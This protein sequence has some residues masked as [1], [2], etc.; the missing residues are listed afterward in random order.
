MMDHIFKDL[1]IQ[2]K[3]PFLADRGP[4][5]A[6]VEVVIRNNRAYGYRDGMPIGLSTYEDIVERLDELGESQKMT[7]KHAQY[8]AALLGAL[9]PESTAL[10][11]SP[12]TLAPTQAPYTL[13]QSA[14]YPKQAEMTERV[15]RIQE[16]WGQM[17]VNRVAQTMGLSR[18]QVVYAIYTY[19]IK[20]VHKKYRPVR[21]SRSTFKG[22]PF[23]YSIYRV[24]QLA[25]R[26]EVLPTETLLAGLRE[27]GWVGDLQARLT[28]RLPAVMPYLQA[29]Q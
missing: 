4:D 13:K 18:H 8:A 29:I 19:G 26:N 27:L 9:T 1:L 6:L 16:L 21:V 25:K 5:G 3:T 17:G 15:A 20:K 23:D 12:T 10:N 14:K 24:H 2:T 7:G 11:I 22:K 28:E